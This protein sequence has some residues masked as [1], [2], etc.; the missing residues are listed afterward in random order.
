MCM[1]SGV[2]EA[3]VK[4]LKVTTGPFL[5]DGLG[6]MSTRVAWS[7]ASCCSM[8]ADELESCSAY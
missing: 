8:A 3:R 1:V 2:A 5:L 6:A 4:L 7:W